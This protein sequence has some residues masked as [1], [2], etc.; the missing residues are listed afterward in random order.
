MK[1]KTL[2]ENASESFGAFY[3]GN[4]G[5]AVQGHSSGSLPVSARVAFFEEEE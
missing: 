3:I 2:V 5:N 1:L 4:F